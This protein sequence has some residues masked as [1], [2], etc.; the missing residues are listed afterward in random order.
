MSSLDGTYNMGGIRVTFRT[1]TPEEDAAR[2][3]Y[4]APMSPCEMRASGLPVICEGHHPDRP[5][6]AN[7]ERIVDGERR[8]VC[9]HHRTGELGA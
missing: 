7:F 1:L 6:S 4:V 3:E 5:R 9:K 2:P 8:G